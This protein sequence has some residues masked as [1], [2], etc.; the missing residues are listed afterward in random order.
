M[1]STGDSLA[2]LGL[3]LAFAYFYI[4]KYD[5]MKPKSKRFMTVLAWLLLAIVVAVYSDDVIIS[6]INAVNAIN[7]GK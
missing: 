2:L 4:E 3:I 1:T 6:V 7:G 5:T